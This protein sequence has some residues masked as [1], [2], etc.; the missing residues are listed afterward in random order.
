MVKHV[1]V[2]GRIYG[3]GPPA[4]F[5]ALVYNIKPIALCQAFFAGKAHFFTG[6]RIVYVGVGVLDDPFTYAWILSH[7]QMFNARDVRR[8]SSSAILPA[9]L[10]TNQQRICTAASLPPNH[11][12]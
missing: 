11:G 12:G 4:V 8:P 3:H 2:L 5:G 7:A 10:N 6:F 1:D 9:L